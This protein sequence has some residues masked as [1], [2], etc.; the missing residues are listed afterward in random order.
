MS[1]VLVIESNTL[2]EAWLLTAAAILEGGREASYDAQPIREV[3]LLTIVVAQPDPADAIIARLG[4]P[5]WLAWM[6]ANFTSL[7]RVAEL[8][9]ADS[10]AT[11]LF[12]YEGRGKDQIR[13]VIDRMN[14]DPT[15]RSATITTFQP[16]TDTSYIP[17]VSM[18]D[19]WAPEGLVDLVV[20]AHG[21]DF[22]KKAYGNLIALAELQAQ[23][24]A[25]VGLPCGRLVLHVK[26]AHIY[27]PEYALMADLVGT[28]GAAPG[29]GASAS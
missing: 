3:E 16:H 12:D 21:L 29:H 26:T 11:R 18:L 22:G 28:A 19:F 10:Y 2:G 8:G 24:A 15:A 13:W 1:A 9:H 23:V 14:G 20:Y 27:A 25:G 4:D 7:D 6:R 5:E 17:C